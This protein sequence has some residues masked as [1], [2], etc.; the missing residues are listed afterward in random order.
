MTKHRGDPAP[1]EDE[2]VAFWPAKLVVVKPLVVKT[3]EPTVPCVV[4]RRGINPRRE[5]HYSMGPHR[6]CDSHGAAY[7]PGTG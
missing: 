3:L 5:V 4:C 6:W 7:G 2:P 1:D